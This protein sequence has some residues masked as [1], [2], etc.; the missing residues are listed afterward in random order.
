MK[1]NL[2][3]AVRQLLACVALMRDG[4]KETASIHADHPSRDIAHQHVSNALPEFDHALRELAVGLGNIKASAE[5][6]EIVAGEPCGA[7]GG[8]GRHEPE[9]SCPSASATTSK[10]P[11]SA[12]FIIDDVVLLVEEDLEL[13]DAVVGL[14]EALT[15]FCDKLAKKESL[16]A[17]NDNGFADAVLPFADAAVRDCVYGFIKTAIASAASR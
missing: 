16:V 8:V 7:C 15:M 5:L 17:A 1:T 2:S 12:T 3:E 14:T 9:C 6:A 13:H 4:I 11:E 10:P